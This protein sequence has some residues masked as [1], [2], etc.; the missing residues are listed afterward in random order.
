MTINL[1]LHFQAYDSVWR[2]AL[3]TKL[4]NIGFGGKT[5]S[6]IRSMYT[7]DSLRFLINGHYTEQL[8]LT[9][10]V[11]QGNIKNYK[12]IKIITIIPRL[13]SFTFAFLLIYQQSWA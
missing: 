2:E 1:V 9:Q 10:G 7:N 13:Q 11:K 8:Y 12:I 4:A 6:L 5:L 3:F